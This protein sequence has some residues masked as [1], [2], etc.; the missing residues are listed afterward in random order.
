MKKIDLSEEFFRAP[1]AHRGL[2][3]CN[4]SF[5]SGKTENSLSA[6]QEAINKGYQFIAYSTDA[7]FM[8]ESSS[9]PSMPK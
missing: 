7:L 8:I 4:E 9:K 2:H 1:I 6:I 3:D 5:G